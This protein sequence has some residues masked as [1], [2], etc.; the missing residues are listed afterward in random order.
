MK[1]K[2]E[3]KRL[4]TDF[5]FKDYHDL[6]V[7]NYTNYKKQMKNL[8][9]KLSKNEKLLKDYNDIFKEQLAHNIEKIS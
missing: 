5:P 2:T 6:L 8:S 9:K 1:F 7:D 3:Q 4:E